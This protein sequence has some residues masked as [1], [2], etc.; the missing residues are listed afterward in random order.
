[1]TS[2]SPV[3]ELET[4]NISK[5]VQDRGNRTVKLSTLT[6]VR[7]FIQSQGHTSCVKW[8]DDKTKQNETLTM[9]DLIVMCTLFNNTILI[10]NHS[11]GTAEALDMEY[12]EQEKSNLSEETDC[13]E[14][15]LFNF[16]RE[17]DAMTMID[18]SES[19]A[20][21]LIDN[22]GLDVKQSVLENPASDAHFA[23]NKNKTPDN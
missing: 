3:H 13:K 19:D 5:L 6:A 4:E 10:F 23:L 2:S 7:D 17:L 8:L 16:E 15:D 9:R 1:M 14:I 11:E 12:N 22:S 21:S 20:L 18:M